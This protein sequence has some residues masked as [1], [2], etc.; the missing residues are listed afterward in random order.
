MATRYVSKLKILAINPIIDKVNWRKDAAGQTV[1]DELN[2]GWSVRFGDS[3]AMHFDE[4]PD[5]EVGDVI[6]MSLEKL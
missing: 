6:K 2:R 3:S 4:R 5:W 1:F